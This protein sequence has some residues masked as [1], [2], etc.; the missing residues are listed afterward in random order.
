MSTYSLDSVSKQSENTMAAV[1]FLLL[2]SVHVAYYYV[3]CAKR[4][5]L[6][7]YALLSHIVLLSVDCKKT[8][9]S[10]CLG[11]TRTF[12]CRVNGRMTTVWKGSAFDCMST[13]N[14]IILLRSSYNNMSSSNSRTCSDGDVAVLAEITSISNNYYTS[15]INV[16][17]KS[18]FTGSVLTITCFQDNGKIEEQVES[19]LITI[20][21]SAGST[22]IC[23]DSIGNV[24]LSDQQFDKTGMQILNHSCYFI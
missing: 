12:L 11:D 22:S 4:R 6:V 7:Q 9:T 10:V 8:N 5:C 15:Q 2:F 16:T 20:E 17:V 1:I 3:S 24:S 23:K 14:Q 18:T 19:Y 21:N 13:N